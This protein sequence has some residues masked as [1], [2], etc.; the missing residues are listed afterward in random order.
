MSVLHTVQHK[1]MIIIC[2]HELKCVAILNNSCSWSE[3][4]GNLFCA[5][6]LSNFESGY[7]TAACKCKTGSHKI[8]S[9]DGKVSIYRSNRQRVNVWMLSLA[10]YLCTIPWV[11]MLY[12]Y[13]SSDSF[14]LFQHCSLHSKCCPCSH[15]GA[16]QSNPSHILLATGQLIMELETIWSNDCFTL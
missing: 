6:W 8:W 14:D 11:Y 13:L 15:L 7:S 16:S 4:K 12:L 5:S 2:K 1:N 10:L 9:W 3:Q